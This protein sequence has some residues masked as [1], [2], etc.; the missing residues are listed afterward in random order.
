MG[1]IE[2]VYTREIV[3]LFPLYNV[4]LSLLFPLCLYYLALYVVVQKLFTYMCLNKN[5][6]LL[7]IVQ[8]MSYILLN[9]FKDFECRT[10]R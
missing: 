4:I 7:Q 9:L 5:K 3:G 6:I 1:E 10:I 2:K 8:Y